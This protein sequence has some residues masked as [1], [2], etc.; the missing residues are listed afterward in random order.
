MDCYSHNLQTT[1]DEIRLQCKNKLDCRVEFTKNLF[2]LSIDDEQKLNAK[3][4]VLKRH[5]Y[6]YEYTIPF[7]NFNDLRCLLEI[8]MGCI[9]IEKRNNSIFLVQNKYLSFDTEEFEHEQHV[10]FS[11]QYI[12]N[13]MPAYLSPYFYDRLRQLFKLGHTEFKQKLIALHYTK[14]PK[15][16]TQIDEFGLIREDFP[17]PLETYICAICKAKGNHFTSF[18]PK[19]TKEKENMYLE[20]QH[21]FYQTNLTRE[22]LQKTY[23][24]S[25]G[26][27]LERMKTSSNY[28]I[29]KGLNVLHGQPKTQLEECQFSEFI[30]MDTSMHVREKEN[31][32]D[33]LPLQYHLKGTS[34]EDLEKTEQ[35]HPELQG[36]IENYDKIINSTISNDISNDM[37]IENFV[38]KNAKN[39]TMHDF[40][41]EV[42]VE[43]LE[44]DD[45][46]QVIDAHTNQIVY[47]RMIKS[48]Y[49]RVKKYAF[50][51]IVQLHLLYL[52]D[53]EENVQ[54]ELKV[55]KKDT[56]CQYYM[57]GL[58][59]K[60]F[61]CDFLHTG[62]KKRVPICQFWLRGEC[63]RKDCEFRHVRA[64]DDK[65]NKECPFYLKGFCHRGSSC[66]LRH[67][68]KQTRYH[69]NQRH[70]IAS[71]PRVFL[72]KKFVEE[73]RS[74]CSYLI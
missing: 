56:L 5:N 70:V 1:I 10:T 15:R 13:P 11:I 23:V 14:L 22:E 36:A 74:N 24:E 55:E 9:K 60:G 69:V 29:N 17:V 40:L 68:K 3:Y 72:N 7:Q 42:E 57:R 59:T 61:S 26:T 63:N 44:N 38:A 31:R 67:V 43:H 6:I 53:F 46:A 47:P 30:T 27:E 52:K 58:C 48:K 39:N 21:V 34:W 66:K 37:E 19:K 28:A 49:Y 62:N 54:K 50:D 71:Y 12:P 4:I 8:F 25:G 41:E 32:T 45:C 16:V 35:K 51:D 18:C 20:A 65:Y 33:L 73:C 64:V 2:D